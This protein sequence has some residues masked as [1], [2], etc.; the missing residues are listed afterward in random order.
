MIYNI[1]GRTSQNLE[2]ETVA[3]LAEIPNIVAIKEASGNLDQ[4]SEIRQLTAPEFKIYSALSQFPL[5]SS[6][7]FSWLVC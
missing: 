3:R 6:F 4:A 5:I 7:L 1:P 2:P